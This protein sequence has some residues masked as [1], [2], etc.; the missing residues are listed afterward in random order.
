MAACIACAS[1][2]L[3]GCSQGTAPEAERGQREDAQETSVISDMQ[4]THTWNLING[5][6]EST[7]DTTPEP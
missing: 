5:T 1:V 3:V 6:P 4:A 7:P 2:L